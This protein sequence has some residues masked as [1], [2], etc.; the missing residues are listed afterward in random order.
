[1][2]APHHRRVVALAALA[3][4]EDRT[5]VARLLGEFRENAPTLQFLKDRNFAPVPAQADF[6]GY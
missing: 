6:S 3:A 2:D 5:W 4:G 1:M